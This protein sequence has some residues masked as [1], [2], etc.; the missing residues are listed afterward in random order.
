MLTTTVLTILLLLLSLALVKLYRELTELRKKGE[1]QISDKQMLQSV[2]RV[3]EDKE[4][5]IQ[6]LELQL[7]NHYDEL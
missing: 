7:K 2:E 6:N 5:K 1:D 4:R 3:L